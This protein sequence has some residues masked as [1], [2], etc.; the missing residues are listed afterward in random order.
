MR[1]LSSSEQLESGGSNCVDSSP[2]LVLVAAAR[3]VSA[4]QSASKIASFGTLLSSHRG[5][6]EGGSTQYGYSTQYTHTA[7]EAHST[8][9]REHSRSTLSEHLPHSFQVSLFAIIANNISELKDLK[10]TMKSGKGY[11][12]EFRGSRHLRTP[13]CNHTP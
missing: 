12:Q 11:Y 13:S 7:S 5:G 1:Q 9:W 4:R 2:R 6:G 8:V 10:R 3:R